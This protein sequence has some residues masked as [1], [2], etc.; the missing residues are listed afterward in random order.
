MPYNPQK[1]AVVVSKPFGAIG[2][3]IDS[4]SFFYDE[5]NFV[6]RAFIS[7]AE[8]LAYFD[9]PFKR[10]GMFYVFVNSTGTLQP[11]GTILGGKRVAYWWKEGTADNQLIVVVEKGDKGDQGEAFT[12]DDFTPEQIEEL[13]QPAI[14]AAVIA[15]TAASN[16]NDK[17]YISIQYQFR[18][19]DL[20]AH[21][22]T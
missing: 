21:V 9:T 10:E 12:Y 19:G 7:T 1:D 6:R 16:A 18:F 14:D 8:V 4:R 2:F 20:S 11:D 17:C 22:T 13:Q 3:P 5:A 15:N